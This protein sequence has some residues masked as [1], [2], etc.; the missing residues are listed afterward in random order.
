M[1]TANQ[2]IIHNET[3]IPYEVESSFA[4]NYEADLCRDITELIEDDNYIV[5]S[6]KYG[7]RYS[8]SGYVHQYSKNNFVIDKVGTHYS[9]EQGVSHLGDTSDGLPGYTIHEFEREVLA[10]IFNVRGDTSIDHWVRYTG[11][12]FIIKKLFTTQGHRNLSIKMNA[13]KLTD[14]TYNDYDVCTFTQASY[15]DYTKCAF[16]F[17]SHILTLVSN[18]NNPVSN[19]ALGLVGTKSSL[20][21]WI[22]TIFRSFKDS[23]AS[24]NDII[25]YIEAEMP[26][27]GILFNPWETLLCSGG[28]NTAEGAYV[29]ESVVLSR[30]INPITNQ[31]DF[32][33]YSITA[34]QWIMPFNSEEEYH[35]VRCAKEMFTLSI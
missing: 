14:D 18:V 17:S 1:I 12:A 4:S 5:A 23:G 15:Y 33:P 13:K 34:K 24:P 20:M 10:M 22:R 35:A 2:I 11:D 32:V 16:D 29:S 30:D 27:G 8:K 9:N 3:E 26:Y 21:S 31:W 6:A 19:E 28:W 25:D 7:D